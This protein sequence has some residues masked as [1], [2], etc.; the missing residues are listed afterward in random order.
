M[1]ST[2]ALIE[3]YD[4]VPEPTAD[5]KAVLKKRLQAT[6]VELDAISAATRAADQS[7]PVEASRWN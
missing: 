4:G 5:L 2:L 1:R 7:S 6:V 3:Y